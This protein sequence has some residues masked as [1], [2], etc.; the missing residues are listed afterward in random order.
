MPVLQ[1]R[2]D[3][4][5]AGWS[6]EVYGAPYRFSLRARFHLTGFE[7][8]NVGQTLNVLWFAVGAVF[9]IAGTNL[10]IL[11]LAKA[12]GREREMG[13]RSAL[14]AGRGRLLRQL[15]VESLALA[16]LGGILGVGIAHLFSDAAA[17]VLPF[18]VAV[19]FRPDGGVVAFSLLVATL[20]ALAFGTAPAWPLLR[21]NPL[22]ALQRPGQGRARALFRG[23]LVAGQTALSITLLIVCGLLGRSMMQAQKVDLGF[24]RQNRLITSLQLDN[25]GVTEEEGFDLISATLAGLQAVPGVEAATTANR[26]PFL[27]SNTASL[28][29]PGTDFAETGLRTGFNL[30]GPGY[31]QLMEIP[32]LAGRGFQESD[33]G[34][35]PVAVVNQVFARQMWPGEDPLGKVFPFYGDDL[36]V[37]GLVEPAV[38][39][40]V[41]EDPWPH[42][43]LSQYQFFVGRM[44]FT[45]ATQ[46][47]PR[48]LTGAVEA[49]LREGTP[50]LAV[51]FLTMD[52]LVAEQ[53]SG[54]RI[55][56][57]FLAL[58]SGV[59]L[60]LA[61]VG[62]YGVQSFL[63]A[64]RTRE[65]GIRLALGAKRSTVIRG[66]LARSLVIAG[67][68][69]VLGVAGGMAASGLVRGFLFGVTPQDPLLLTGV[70]VLMLVACLVA[71]LGPAR[72]ASP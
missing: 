67:I 27:G 61:M 51:A 20:A 2:W 39:Y 12:A 63:V 3:Q 36:T 62:L 18:S 65:I 38:Y 43:Y 40:D 7:A 54:Y 55:R 25:H 11:L 21:L 22:N 66:I 23:G 68:G 26:V 48:A 52:Q 35:G 42:V 17:A 19:N 64:R 41:R 59:A 1:R 6:E 69:G 13:I 32:L 4:E 8:R 45:V 9:L 47:D 37:V 71:S 58:F 50:D 60:L 44:S 72:R 33:R 49:A 16:A 29:V 15:L 57:T 28:R 31:F 10:A 24:Q 14:G 30:V 5:F 46:G 70:P 53:L 56:T 34:T